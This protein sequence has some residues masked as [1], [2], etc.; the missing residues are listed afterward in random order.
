LADLA[1]P[2][3]H[4]GLVDLTSGCGGRIIR[5]KSNSNAY[6]QLMDIIKTRWYPP[7]FAGVIVLLGLYVSSLYNYLLFH[8]IA[9]VFSIVIAFGI[10][11]VA[12]NSRRFLD[13][14]FFVYVGIAYL[15]VGGI[16]LV[17]TLAYPGMG[18]FPGYGTN[19]AAQLWIIARYIESLS[20]LIAL[21][22]I[23]LKL[24]SRFIFLGYSLVIS[25]LLVSIFY[26]NIFPITFVE[27]IGL[28]PFKKIS[29]YVISSILLGSVFVMFRK[30]REFDIRV[31]RLLVAAIIVTILSELSFTL[32]E[33][34]F[35]LPN[36]IGHFLKI[37]SFYLIYKAIIETG[38]VRPYDLLFR[39]LKHS[40]EQYRDLYEEAPSAYFS[41]GADGGIRQANRSAV[42]LVGY[43]LDELIGR[44]VL[45]LYADTPNGKPKAKGVFQNF[46][47]GREIHGEE[48]EMCRA[49]GSNIWISLSVRPLYDEEGRVVLSRFQAVDI[50]DRKQAEERIR[51]QKELLENTLESLTHPFYVVNVNDH[52]I[53]IANSAA[54]LGKPIGNQKCYT[55]THGNS[56]PC[57]GLE[58]PCPLEEVKNTGKPST[59]E[60]IHYNEYGTTTNVEVHGYPIF[61]KEGNVTRMITYSID[62]TERKKLDQLKDDF[63]GL[64]SHELR[65]PL[66]VITGAVNTVLTEGARLS[67]E[68]TR[69]L[70][71]DAALEADL[72][73]H[74]LSNLLELSR[75]QANRLLIHAE[76]VSVARIV[77]DTFEE[78]K[79]QA[80]PHQFILDIPKKLPTVYADRLRLERILYNL[81]DN[82]MKYSPQGGEVRVSVKSEDERLVISV[83]DQGIGIS[84][85]DQ[86]KLFGPFQRI[87]ESKLEGV[88]GLG[89]GL[90]V[91]RRLVET[92]GGQIWVESEPGKGST[93]FFT[94]PLSNS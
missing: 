72:L 27:G 77:Q 91:C 28:T 31:L 67:P 18:V 83:S 43:R 16:D 21:L 60:H 87:E 89:L 42:D 41:I 79:R 40:E 7:I 71:T 58:H 78:I 6:L 13:N 88:R 46:R 93:F 3:L 39:N 33:S 47:A 55:M 62:I 34:P 2:L 80:S 59:V 48:L 92:H 50:T 69:Q 66:T 81:I 84:L 73:S 9:E 12:W 85:T 23:G 45:D 17:H 61:D 64:V 53:E 11:V 15:F 76:P 70:I 65:S 10:F 5:I 57:S 38:L 94:L 19:L 56:K 25:F 37:T 26:W 52:T 63:I 49:D 29:E 20:L 22:L 30:H 4:Y 90:L 54:R 75:A 36:L 86:A 24:R 82:A 35:G 51:Y 68:E 44:P 1:L 8:S 74:L 32:Y 14:A